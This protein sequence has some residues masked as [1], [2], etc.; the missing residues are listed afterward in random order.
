MSRK[1]T[2]RYRCWEC[3]HRWRARSTDRGDLYWEQ[4]V[5]QC[6]ECGSRRFEERF[7]DGG[8]MQPYVPKDQR[9][10]A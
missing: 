10:A 6:P 8:V 7:P 2:S 3:G 9:G 5:E 1:P 4:H